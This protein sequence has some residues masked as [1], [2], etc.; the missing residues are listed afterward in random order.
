MAGIIEIFLYLMASL[1]MVPAIVLAMQ[2]IIA[3]LPWRERLIPTGRRPRL[4]VLMPAHNES[5]IIDTTIRGLIAGLSMGDRLLVVADNCTDDTA[6]I[7]AAAGAEVVERDNPEYRGKSYA[8]DFGVRYLRGDPPEVLIVLD[9]DCEVSAASLNRVAI[10]AVMKQRPVQAR[11]IMSAP[12]GAAL[13]TR[14]AAFAWLVKNHVRALGYY[15]IGMPCQLMGSGMAFPWHL[16]CAANLASGHL[17]E[18]LKLGADLALAGT[19][20]LFCPEAIVGS[21]FPV[22]AEGISSQRTRWEH[23]H[24][25]VIIEAGPRLFWRALMQFDIRILGFA[26]DLCVPPL[27]LLLLLTL[28]LCGV[29]AVFFAL[30]GISGPLNVST[31]AFAVIGGAVMFAW[32]RF[33]RHV[34]SIGGLAY[35]PFYVLW[36]VPLYCKF[37][38]NRQVEWVRSKRDGN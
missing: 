17:S 21:Q 27:A 2:V 38:L 19:P 30:T 12:Q 4:A 15:R 25:W 3:V 29:S 26:L 11:Y 1:V 33:G 36:K 24:L 32:L 9:A 37:L 14:I 34:I 31:M 7:A 23:G 10:V 16:I 28:I 13:K 18:D 22:A 5:L 8:L 6:R 35:A 20:T